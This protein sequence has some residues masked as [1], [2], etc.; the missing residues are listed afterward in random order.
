MNRVY[1]CI[2]C[3]NSCEIAVEYEGKQLLKAEGYKCENGR[4]YVEQELSDP[5][6]TITSSVLVEGGERPLASV[7]LTAPI[8][9]DLIFPLMEK[10]QTIIKRQ[11]PL[12]L[13]VRLG[14]WVYFG[15]NPLHSR[16]CGHTRLG[17]SLQ[18]QN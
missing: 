3:P 12:G 8:S 6:R 1:T 18:R 14:C 7:R 2:L 17:A 16:P 13:P 5:K 10:I 4:K 15:K 9:R 11:P